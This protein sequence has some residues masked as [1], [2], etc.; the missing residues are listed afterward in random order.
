MEHRNRELLDANEK[1]LEADRKKTAFLQDMMHQIRT[2]LNIIGGFAQVLNEN[3]HEMPSDESKRIIQL[4]QDNV[5][6]ILRISRM[7]MI[8][9]SPRGHLALTKETFS[10]NELCRELIGSFQ[11]TNP[12]TVKLYFETTVPDDF[13]ICTD[14]QRVKLILE[15]LLDNANKFTHQGSIIV[16]VSRL[17]DKMVTITV[18]DT[19]IGIAEA[20]RQMMAGVGG[21]AEQD[22]VTAMLERIGSE[23][24]KLALCVAFCRNSYE[25]ML[26]KE[27]NQWYWDYMEEAGYTEDGDYNYDNINNVAKDKED[28]LSRQLK[29]RMK[30]MFSLFFSL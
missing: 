20:H 3:F 8:F 21:D 2:P 25:A 15:E 4:M 1:A 17:D 11:L 13:M 16:A 24:E 23:I 9:A 27:T 26:H 6:K 19:G 7:F 22:N 5:K 12:Y 29:N 10:C 18:S 28:E 14:K 30:I